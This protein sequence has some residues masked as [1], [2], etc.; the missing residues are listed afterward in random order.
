MPPLDHET[1]LFDPSFSLGSN[2]PH[3]PEFRSSSPG[4]SP[5]R[6]TSTTTTAPDDND[7]GAIEETESALSP[8]SPSSTHSPLSLSPPSP[9]PQSPPWTMTQSQEPASSS[10]DTKNSDSQRIAWHEDDS[11]PSKANGAAGRR[12]QLKQKKRPF[13]HLRGYDDTDETDW[14]LAGSAFPLVSNVHER[15]L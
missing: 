7:N 9:P 5:V 3:E 11:P 4:T 6:R 10:N 15:R 14:W 8:S 2:H 1:S 12:L 13:F